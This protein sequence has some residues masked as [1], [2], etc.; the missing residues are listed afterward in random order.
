M[1]FLSRKFNSVHFRCLKEHYILNV[2]DW[3]K[4]QWQEKE[5]GRLFHYKAVQYD[6]N[7]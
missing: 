3:L 5:M 2:S 6:K 7:S 4:C 1:M